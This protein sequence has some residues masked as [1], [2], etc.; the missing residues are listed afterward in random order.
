M[1]LE[2][3]AEVIKQGDSGDVFFVVEKGSLDVLIDGIKVSV[4]PS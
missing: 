2:A 3:G 4:I 1:V